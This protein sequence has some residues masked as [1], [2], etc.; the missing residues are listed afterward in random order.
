[1]GASKE[2]QSA[3]DETKPR[4]EQDAEKLDDQK[5]LNERT[6]HKLIPLLVPPWDKALDQKPC[7]LHNSAVQDY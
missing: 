6:P 4:L 5:T 3:Q 1:M 2:E 7:D